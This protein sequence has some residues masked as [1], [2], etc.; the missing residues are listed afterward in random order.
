MSS[1]TIEDVEHVKLKIRRDMLRQVGRCING[2]TIGLISRKGVE[3]GPVVRGG[4]CQRCLDVWQVS[5]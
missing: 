3:H 5:K 4:K 1:L 2:P